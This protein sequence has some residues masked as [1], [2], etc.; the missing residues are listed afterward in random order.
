MG[1][2]FGYLGLLAAV[3]IMGFLYAKNAQSISGGTAPTRTVVD[4]TAV[5]NDLISMANAERQYMASNSKYASL[6]ELKANGTMNLVD[7]KRE[8]WTYSTDIGEQTFKI[9]ATNSGPALEG[10]PRE[11]TIDQN[12]TLEKH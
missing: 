4:I 7:R 9:I 8:G 2:A 5:Q 10:V 6:D 3:A 12:M 11:I 1:R